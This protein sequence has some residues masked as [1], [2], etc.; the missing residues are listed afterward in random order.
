MGAGLGAAQL[1][2][3]AADHDLALV[4]D[5]VLDQ[6][7]EAERLRHSVDE[8]DHVDAEGALHRGPL[9]ELVEHY[10]GRV[11][12]AL[13]LDHQAH[14]GAIGLVAQVGDAGDLFVADEVGDL[15]DQAAFAALLDHEGQLGDDDRVA[16]TLERLDV[17]AGADP[18]RGAAGGVG[19]GD[20]FGAHDAAAGEVG[21]LDVLHQPGEVDPGVGDVGLDRADRLAQVVRRD[22]GRHPDRDP[23]RAVDQQ[24][25]KARRQHQRLLLGLVVVRSPL[26]GVGVDVAQQ[27]GR[28]AGQAR[29]GVPHRG[30]WIVVDR[31][32][33]ALAVDEHVAQREGLR[34]PCQRVVDRRV[35]VR[36]VLAHHLADDEGGLAVG[37]VRLQGEVVHRVEHAP[38]HRLEAVAH[39]GQRPADDHA[40]RV[41]EIRR[42]HL[43]RQLALLDPPAGE[44]FC[45]LH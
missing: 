21:A 28:E 9:V 24:V 42:A 12:A 10:L 31:A 39:V 3:G 15:R 23:G 33:V 40:H 22:V 8:G 5:V 29:L 44:C 13:G 45:A 32:E 30:G 7:L 36:V 20:A 43:G 6:L 14:A 34:H 19:V 17:G 1:V 4:V 11:A 27:L 38:V 2:L 16:A 25:G 18:H 35:A 26:D 37:P 41:V